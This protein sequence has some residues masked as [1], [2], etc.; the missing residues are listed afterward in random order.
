M[1][2]GMLEYYEN[3]LTFL[4]DEGKRFAQKYPKIAGRLQLESDRC[5]DPHVNRLLQGFALLAA[6]VHRKIDDDFPEICQALL[7]LVSPG[8]L[9]PVPSMTIVEFLTDPK[10]GRQTV[11]QCIPR[12]TDLATKATVDGLPCRFRTAYDVTLWP[13]SVAEAGWSQPER[14]KRPVRASS[15]EFAA[16]AVRLLLRCHPDV[17]FKGLP[18]HTIRMHLAGGSNAGSGVVYSLYELLADRCFEIQLRDPRDES[19][20]IP[21]PASNLKPVGFSPAT[22]ALLPFG[23]RSVDGHRLLEEYFVFPEKFLFFDLEGLEPLGE[24]GFGEEAEIVFLLRP[25]ERPERQQA[26]E[27]GVNAATFRLGCTPAINLFSVAAEPIPLTQI[28]HEY[29]IVLASNPHHRAYMEVFKIEEVIATHRRLRRFT[30]LEPLLAYRYQTRKSK[31]LAFWVSRRRF[32]TVEERNPSAMGISVVDLDGAFT[33]PDAD[34]L[35]IRALCSNHN[36][37]SHPKMPWS[38]PS[39][40]FEAAGCATANTVTALSRPTPSLPAHSQDS[41]LWRL[42]SMMSLNFLSLVEG[43]MPALKEILRLHNRSDSIACENQVG[44]L[45]SLRSEF[46]FALVDS[47]YGLIPARGTK[48]T[49]EFDEQQ[50]A[51]AGLYLYASILD[52]FLGN[53]ASMN[54]FTQL[55]VSARKEQRKEAM[56]KWPPRSG[57]QALL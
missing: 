44:A 14:M 21:L 41:Y 17:Q 54:S 25:F 15:G 24:A 19:R 18:I 48:V 7:E 27:M 34:T 9:R 30:K 45:T 50:F 53:Y 4:R 6:R 26:L 52:R 35:D 20:T 8:Y 2:D 51:G 3:E 32:D 16:G 57:N 13:F 23:R 31:D 28:R 56:A 11:G 49:M 40:D 12:A 42:I 5:E 10:Q 37:P 47:E 1:G 39:G 36:L 22:E 55:T 29:P 33:D 46:G 43:G 38:S